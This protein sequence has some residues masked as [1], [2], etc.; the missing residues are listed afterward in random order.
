MSKREA[1]SDTKTVPKSPLLSTRGRLRYRPSDRGDDQPVSPPG[2]T[3]DTK[4]V[5]QEEHASMIEYIR[6]SPWQADLVRSWKFAGFGP[7]TL[8]KILIDYAE[9]VLSVRATWMFRETN[10]PSAVGRTGRNA[11]FAP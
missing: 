6:V 3:N 7:E 9:S 10:G 11:V 5:K 2:R 1:A 8:T 4:Q